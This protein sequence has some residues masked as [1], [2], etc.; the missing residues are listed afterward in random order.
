MTH[1]DALTTSA[2]IGPGLVSR[3]DGC[4]VRY[5]GPEGVVFAS[6]STASMIWSRT[7][8]LACHQPPPVRR[9]STAFH[10]VTV[11]PR[12]QL[13]VVKIKRKGPR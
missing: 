8:T 2:D 5:T 10:L 13:L 1:P 12:D 3:F 6:R 7:A 9:P 11:P 4:E